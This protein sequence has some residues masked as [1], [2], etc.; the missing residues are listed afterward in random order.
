MET[1][2]LFARATAERG[3]EGWASFFTEDA[4]MMPG[5][6]FPVV[7]RP[8]ILETMTPVFA[9]PGYSLTWE[10]DSAEVADSGDL[11]FTVGQYVST[12]RDG[13]GNPV[14]SKG[15][16]VTIWKKQ[17]DGQWRAILDIGNENPAQ[18]N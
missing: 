12:S 1:D 5:G 8:K 4:V 11:G 15:K 10:P 3:A 17:A 2:R 13:D 6:S 7:G 18:E 14:V 9:N 16:Y